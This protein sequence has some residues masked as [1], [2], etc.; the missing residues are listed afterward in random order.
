MSFLQPWMLIALPLIAAPIV[1]HLVNQLR[2]QTVPWAAMMFLLQASKMSSGYTKLRQWLILIM[3]TLAVACLIFFTARPLASGLLGL[4]GNRTDEVAVVLLDRSPSMQQS[5]LGTG[6]TK[7]QSAL[8]QLAS[9]LETLGVKR[10]AVFDSATDKP[11]EFESPNELSK[12]PALVPN[13]VTSDLPG[14]MERALQFIKSRRFASTDVWICSDM[15]E[16]DWHSRDGRWVASREGF[17]SLAQEV[18]FHVLDLNNISSENLSLHLVSAKRIQ[19][20]KG[21]ELSLSFKI[22]R[23]GTD[24][25]KGDADELAANSLP[26]IQVPVELEVGSVRSVLNVDLQSNFAEVSDYRI[27]LE[28]KDGAL[29]T[30]ESIDTTGW[31]RISIPADTNLAD[32][33]SYFAFE[34]PPVR[35]SII[36]SDNPGMIEAIELCTTISPEQSIQCE[37]EI[38]TSSQLDSVDWN[39]ISMVVWHEQLPQ[40]RPLELLT[41]F[42]KTGGKILF[43]P[44]ESPN[45]DRAFGLRWTNWESVQ[46][47]LEPTPDNSDVEMSQDRQLSLL[48]RVQQWRNDSELLSN[49]L[50]GAALP[51]GQIGIK[52]ICR[53][54]GEGTTLASI[55][56]NIPLLI[57]MDEDAASNSVN[58]GNSGVYVCTTT[59][60]TRDSTLAVDGIVMYIAIQRVLAAGSER[61]GV[62]KIVTVGQP[63]KLQFE[64]AVQEAGDQT[65]F[66]SDYAD[67]TGVYRTPGLLIAQ[68]RT[69]EED[70]PKTVEDPVLSDIF[71]NLKWSRIESGANANSLVQEIWKWFL[72]AML[73]ALMLES[74][75]CIPKRRKTLASQPRS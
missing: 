74:I 20:S 12:N 32:N 59:P 26:S 47:S 73:S 29:K 36:V 58:T 30:D 40:G 53:L 33:S 4:M 60:S 42:V 67:N 72:I 48:A 21:A 68:N 5:L 54:D 7:Q 44:P 55:Q 70:N 25:A 15:R 75:L 43:F 28:S 6:L 52:R 8:M 39:A 2:F 41:E 62:S 51:V 63:N 1:I 46:P 18:R 31:G 34:K 23:A 17:L 61:V 24:R 66:S 14:L 16:S 49:T 11:L 45:N 50:N 65:I 27:P 37:T 10:V 9:T 57:R 69:I 64:R 35:R 3:R 22:E 13:G 38:V 19:E 71:G 56:D